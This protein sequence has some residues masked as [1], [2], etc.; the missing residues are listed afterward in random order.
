MS[1][2]DAFENGVV[3]GTVMVELGLFLGGGVL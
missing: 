1:E 2:N 3:G